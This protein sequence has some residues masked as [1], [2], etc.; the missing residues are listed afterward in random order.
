MIKNKLL[1]MFI[2]FNLNAMNIEQERYLDTTFGNNGKVITDFGISS[3]TFN[4][5]IPAI[6]V[7]IQKDGKILVICDVY[8]DYNNK[9]PRSKVALIRYNQNGSLDSNFGDSGKVILSFNSMPEGNSYGMDFVIQN[10][11]KIVVLGRS[12]K[13]FLEGSGALVRLNADGS[14]DKT[15]GI[16]GFVEVKPDENHWCNFFRIILQEDGKFIMIGNQGK[17]RLTKDKVELEYCSLFMARYNND[18]TPDYSFGNEGKLKTIF[19]SKYERKPADGAY[20]LAAQSNGKIVAVGSYEDAEDVSYSSLDSSDALQDETLF[21]NLHTT[22]SSSGAIVRYKI[23][24]ELDSTFGID[25]NGIV[26]VDRSKFNRN[27]FVDLIVQ[28]DDKIVAVGFH[29][30]LSTE[31]SE[32]MLIRYTENGLIDESFG[33]KGIILSPLGSKDAILTHAILQEDGKILVTGKVTWDNKSKFTLVRYTKE[34][35][36][37]KTFGENG[38]LTTSIRENFD[39]KSFSI[40]IQEDGKVVLAGESFTTSHSD[41]ALVRYNKFE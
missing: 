6:H 34:G 32:F 22:K 5:I 25:K 24:G 36:I 27:S 1:F 21:L 11:D 7:K 8:Q 12:F 29:K 14:I 19:P 2:V 3:G 17:D 9:N 15:F 37:D 4:R 41:F 13:N 23:S 35:L 26:I 39:D 28:P 31:Y 30:N 40:A 18:G 20:S 38:I 10:D 33:D 16:D